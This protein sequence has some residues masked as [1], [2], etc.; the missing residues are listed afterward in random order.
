LLK[1][2]FSIYDFGLSDRPVVNVNFDRAVWG[3]AFRKVP[4][5]PLAGVHV[6]GQGLPTRA[7]LSRFLADSLLRPAQVATGR[8]VPLAR[9]PSLLDF[10]VETEVEPFQTAA[11]HMHLDVGRAA[12]VTKCDVVGDVAELS[13][14]GTVR[15]HCRVQLSTQRA[16]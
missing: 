16:P 14:E 6:F 2:N 4:S 9:L 3:S 11:W 15:E 12:I 5:G 8:I 1:K 10:D 7:L 13:V